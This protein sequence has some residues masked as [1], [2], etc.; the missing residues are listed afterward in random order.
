MSSGACSRASVRCGRKVLRLALVARAVRAGAATSSASAVQPVHR[1]RD[2]RR[3]DRAPDCGFR[4]R[5]P[6]RRARTIARRRA[7][8]AQRPTT[9]SMSASLPR[10]CTVM[11]HCSRGVRRAAGIDDGRSAPR[12]RRAPTSGGR[13]ATNAR[14][15]RITV[16]QA[17]LVAFGI[18]HHDPVQP[19]LFERLVTARRRRAPR[20]G[21][22]PPRCSSDDEVEV[23]PVLRRLRLGH[24]LEHEL[25]AD[26]VGRDH[27]RGTGRRRCRALT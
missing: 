5:R 4:R 25:R 6:R 10:N 17:D 19:V 8:L 27:R 2:A 22:P 12:P 9:A 21:R 24:L 15:T 1:P 14:V 3:E 13:I 23:H 11:C 16:A 20:T 7:Q 26:A 18:V